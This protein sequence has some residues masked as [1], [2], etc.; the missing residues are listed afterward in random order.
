MESR[1]HKLA[2]VA[3]RAIVVA[4][5][6]ALSVPAWWSVVWVLQGLGVFALGPCPDGPVLLV[7][8]AWLLLPA[9][10]F[11]AFEVG[12]RTARRIELGNP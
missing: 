8:L 3:I 6:T 4:A 11:V 5:V 10:L 2:L 1:A 9:L 7:L 12:M